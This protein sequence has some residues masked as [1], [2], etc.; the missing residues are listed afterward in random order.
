M[1][2]RIDWYLRRDELRPEQIFTT[3]DG[4]KVKLDRR[5]PGDG[6]QWYAADWHD[7]GWT[8]DDNRIEPGDLIDKVG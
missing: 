1:A 2:E 7:G 5:V 4:G 6:T 8:Y 3:E